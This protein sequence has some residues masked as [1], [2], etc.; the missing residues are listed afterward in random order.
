MELFWL[1]GVERYS[2]DDDVFEDNSGPSTFLYRAD[3][4][5]ASG[6]CLRTYNGR[7]TRR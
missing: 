6:G 5:Q 4:R 7:L 2:V 3:L 1:D